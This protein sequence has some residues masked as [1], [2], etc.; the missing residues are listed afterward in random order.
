LSLGLA[1]LTRSAVAECKLGSCSSCAEGQCNPG[2]ECYDSSPEDYDPTYC[3]DCPG[4]DCGGSDG[5]D[6][7][8]D[9]DPS[10]GCPGKEN[11]PVALIL[12]VMGGFFFCL[13]PCGTLCYRSQ[14]QYR[15]EF[16][17]SSSVTVGRT[18]AEVKKK[19]TETSDKGGVTH[20]FE[21]QFVAQRR[22]GE[23]YLVDAKR[24]VQQQTYE[25]AQIGAQLECAFRLGNEREFMLV[26]DVRAQ[27]EGCSLTMI[28]CFLG[29]F[30]LV[31]VALAGASF[32][33][34]GCPLGF[35]PF[36]LLI[37]G[38]SLLGWKGCMPLVRKLTSSSFYVTVKPY[39][40]LAPPMEMMQA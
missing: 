40:N 29:C 9:V 25:S 36:G 18:Q 2:N 24:T 8:L 22:P 15:D 13:L 39:N 10:L 32:P 6:N 30:A 16:L 4:G 1:S 28:V 37:V 33:L 35:I 27:P 7:G 21:V 12:G 19:W 3:V 26:E 11:L 23:A 31:G 17:S 38:G 34:T 5:G 20:M 14:K